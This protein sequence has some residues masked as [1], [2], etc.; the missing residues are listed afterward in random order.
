[1]GEIKPSIQG[2]L[3]GIID[4]LLLSPQSQ[5]IILVVCCVGLLAHL[6]V[7]VG[8]VGKKIGDYDVNR[9][10]GRRFLTHEDL[11]EGGQCF[12]YMPISALYW[13]PMAL[14][15]PRVGMACRY[16]MAI[17]CLALTFRILS[18]MAFPD[19]QR[20]QRKVTATA[21]ISLILAVHY[22]LRDFD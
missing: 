21:L 2:S 8:R 9:E 13:A 16:L 1:M 4:G 11:Y 5:R 17:V 12:N 15:P 20:D 18:S 22:L 6:T 7:T 19:R 3:R 14:V 10:F